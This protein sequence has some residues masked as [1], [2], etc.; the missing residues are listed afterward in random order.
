MKNYISVIIIVVASLFSSC[1]NML[2]LYPHS[3]VSPD[4]V[5][6]NDI[7]AL[8]NGMYYSVQNSPQVRSY[9]MFDILG[10]DLT[11]S[12]YNPLDIINTMLS[13]L[14]SYMSGGWNGYY[15]AIYQINNVL[16]VTERF[17]NSEISQRTRGEAFYLRAYVYYCLLAR[18]GDVPILRKNTMDKVFRDPVSDV[19]TFIEDD[20]NNASSLLGASTNYYYVSYDAVT[21]LQARVYLCQGKKKE[22][23]DAAESLIGT[24]KLD[25]FEKIFRKLSNT[26]IIF[27]FENLSEES[28]I[29]ISDLFY[30]YG[31]PNKGQGSY[32]LTSAAVAMY[33]D[34]D[35]RKSITVINISGT[36]C[37]NKYPSGQTGKDPVIISRVAEMYLISA[38][39]Q[40]SVNGLGRLNELRIKRGLGAISPSS[41][42]QFLNAVLEE[43]RRELLGENLRYHD[44]VR[45]GKAVSTLGIQPHQ[46]LLPMP[47]NELQRNPN[48]TPNPGY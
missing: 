37:V 15:D 5:T 17:P 31:H 48:L 21:A 3:A 32:K 36:D 38:E 13:P 10:G 18:W 9:I 44:L 40:G 2:D 33:D 35:N 25:S 39:A 14:S 29:N 6:E 23:A 24:Y 41:S 34:N 26:E 45:T 22:A 4:A 43:R 42:D 8:R 7:M 27:A 12:T 19:W 20:L 11:S 30:T 46:T 47:G 1:S 16:S 28:S